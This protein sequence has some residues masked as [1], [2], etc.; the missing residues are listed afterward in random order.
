MAT[1]R[2]ERV[3]R[4]GFGMA[5][6]DDE[7][8]PAEGRQP[9]GDIGDGLVAS[10]RSLDDLAVAVE[11][12]AARRDHDL[13]LDSGDELADRKGV[14]E[15]VGDQQQRRVGEGRQR[16]VP[17]GL[18][19]SLR[20]RLAEYWA[21]LDEMDRRSKS[22]RAHHA[23]SVR[24]ERSP[25]GAEFDVNRVTRLAGTC[26]AIGEAGA[27]KLAEHLADFR[28]GGEIPPRS[29]RVARC[30][31]ISVAG[32]HERLDRHGTFGKDSVP[33]RALQRS[34]ETLAAPAVGSTR[35]RRPFAV[36]ISQIPPMMSG[37]DSHWPM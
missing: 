28:S 1:N 25:A 18:G 36:H 22:G 15:F 3:A 5:I 11:G 33:E 37:S 20:L 31:I 35:T 13:A 4:S 21:G 29:Q 34:H 23:K 2:L 32:A 10:G 12:E 14:E 8:G 16:I 9:A 19:N 27:D 7:G 26:P 17:S 24:C 6:V 30:V